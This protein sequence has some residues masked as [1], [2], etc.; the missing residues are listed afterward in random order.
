MS[1]D[2]VNFDNLNDF[3]KE[4]YEQNDIE[5]IFDNKDPIM[6]EISRIIHYNENTRKENMSK[7][8]VSKYR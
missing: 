2:K 6:P 8:N 5:I 1:A 7:K 3:L 4:N